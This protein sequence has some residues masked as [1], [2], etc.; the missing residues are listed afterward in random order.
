MVVVGGSLL[1]KPELRAEIEAAVREVVTTTKQ[2]AGCNRYDF[3]W[4]VLQP[5]MLGVLEE[6]ESR[7][8]LDAH[9]AMPHTTKFLSLVPGFAASPVDVKIYTVEK[10]ESL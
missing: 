9:L 8:H 7:A 4:D 10:A 6:W 3:Y 5:N 1:V 2:E